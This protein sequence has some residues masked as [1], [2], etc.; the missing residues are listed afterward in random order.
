MVDYPKSLVFVWVEHTMILKIYENM[1]QNTRRDDS[2]NVVHPSFQNHGWRNITTWWLVN[3]HP[4]A[5]YAQEGKLNTAVLQETNGSWASKKTLFLRGYVGRGVGWPATTTLFQVIN[6]ESANDRFPLNIPP[7][8]RS[9]S[10]TFPPPPF[11]GV[12]WR[13]THCACAMNMPQPRSQI[14]ADRHSPTVD[15][16]NPA[17]RLR[18]VAYPMICLGCK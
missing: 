6:K 10:T 17:N 13:F 9:G 8:V 12:R 4:R 18:L 5:T 14:P 7:P 3:L 15:G 11:H 16:R 2:W 1:M